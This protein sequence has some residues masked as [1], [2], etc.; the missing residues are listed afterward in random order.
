[1]EVCGSCD[2]LAGVNDLLGLHIDMQARVGL[3]L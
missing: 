2:G 3:D 1:M